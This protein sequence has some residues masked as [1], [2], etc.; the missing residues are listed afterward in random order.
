MN[1][2]IFAL[3]MSV[4]MILTCVFSFASCMGSTDN[5]GN[6]NGGGTAV[7]TP[8]SGAHKDNNCDGKCDLKN[9]DGKVC[10]KAATVTHTY[11]ATRAEDGRIGFKVY[12]PSRTA[13]VLKP[14]RSRKK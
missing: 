4:L 5:G 9:S 7:V 13:M 3:A 14:I 8:H 12:L 6:N 10:G 11:E 2:R 1:K